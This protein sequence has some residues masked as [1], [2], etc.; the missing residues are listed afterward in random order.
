MGN[1]IKNHP[2]VAYPPTDRTPQPTAVGRLVSSNIRAGKT[3]QVTGRVNLGR[4]GEATFLAGVT[5]ES[6]CRWL[7]MCDAAA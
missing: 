6:E 2:T 4:R 1:W 5:D 3:F 7:Y